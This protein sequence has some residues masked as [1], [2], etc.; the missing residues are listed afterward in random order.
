MA[1]HRAKAPRLAGRASNWTPGTTVT[2]RCSEGP[3][4]LDSAWCTSRLLLPLRAR[5]LARRG[6]QRSGCRHGC[7]CPHWSFLRAT[8][9]STGPQIPGRS[10]RAPRAAA[11]RGPPFQPL[12]GVRF[13]PQRAHRPGRPAGAARTRQLA[14]PADGDATT[15]PALRDGSS[16]G[17]VQKIKTAAR[18]DV[19]SV[20]DAD[21]GRRVR[22]RIDA[23]FGGRPGGRSTV[24]DWKTGHPEP[25]ELRRRGAGSSSNGWP[26]LQL[27]GVPRGPVPGPRLQL[28]AARPHPAAAVC[29]IGRLAALI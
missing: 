17:M 23:V 10:P 19:R 22:G 5:R 14:N 12:A 21:A 16:P 9:A 7:P 15:L 2:G 20:P 28:R 18:W 29:W 26:G 4:R 11:R 27:A 6:R 3:V 8:P 25:P 13:S 1:R 24:V